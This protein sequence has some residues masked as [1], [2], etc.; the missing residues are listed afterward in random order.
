MSWNLLMV[1]CPRAVADQLREVTSPTLMQFELLGSSLDDAFDKRVESADIVVIHE[2]D[3]EP[4]LPR[5]C[6]RVRRLTDVP[7]IT[8]VERYDEQTMSETFD[9]G[10]NDY[11]YP[12]CSHRELLARIR[13][14]LRR[15]HEYASKGTRA[16]RYE[17]DGI[18]VD[19]SRHE[20]I[21]RGKS[22]TLTPKEFD[23][24]RM[25]VCHVDKAISREQ[26]LQDIWHIGE[27][28]NTRTLD[29]HI[30]RLRHKIEQDPGNPQL[31]VTVPGYGYKLRA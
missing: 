24:L 2:N 28:G 14:Q 12:D 16:E 9:A 22:A 30:G 27:G 4:P 20:V 6:E 19:V 15:A 10:A 21:V 31:I 18:T 11:I 1:G 29:V 26:L 3:S 8:L 25:L 13:A 7:I 17:L 23:L 5:V